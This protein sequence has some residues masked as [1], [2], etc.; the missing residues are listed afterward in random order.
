MY[1][2]ASPPRLPLVARSTG[3]LAVVTVT[4]VAVL[5][6]PSARAETERRTCGLNPP[7]SLTVVAGNG[8][9]GRAL[10]VGIDNPLGTQAPGSATY[11]L[12]SVAPDGGAP[13]GSTAFGLSMYGYGVPGELTVSLDDALFLGVWSGGAWN[14]PGTVSTVLLV[15]PDDPS[16]VG[17]RVDLQGLVVDGSGSGAVVV[18]ATEGLRVTLEAACSEHAPCFEQMD[19]GARVIDLRVS[20]ALTEGGATVDEHW[21]DEELSPLTTFAEDGGVELPVPNGAALANAVADHASIVGARRI[22]ASLEVGAH[23]SGAL[24]DRVS[25]ARSELWL[26]FELTTRV[27]A[28]LAVDAFAES[29]LS[30]AVAV[31]LSDGTQLFNT[32]ATNGE[33][34]ADAWSGWLDPATYTLIASNIAQVQSTGADTTGSLDLD[35]R[36]FHAADLDLD[37]VVD[38]EDL[39]AFALAFAVASPTVDMDGDG[40]VDGDDQQLFDAAYAAAQ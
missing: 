12:A 39:T 34:E 7:D 32:T 17:T 35:L 19:V 36:L 14:G 26:E 30:Q 18:G 22:A 15:P 25:R 4:L 11:L 37:G 9:L 29:G 23:A 40:D 13:C 10:V 28:S 16:L 6:A 5:T 21:C 2:V 8:V 3:T 1:P 27:R 20:G 33:F 24:F 31:V 38:G